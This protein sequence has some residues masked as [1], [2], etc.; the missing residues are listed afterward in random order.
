MSSKK[1]NAKLEKTESLLSE[2]GYVLRFEKGNFNSGYCVLEHRK[3]IVIN[4]FLDSSA[5]LQVISELIVRLNIDTN[6]LTPASKALY[7]KLMTNSEKADILH[8]VV[9]QKID[10]G[11]QNK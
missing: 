9:E 2:A 8:P 10:L 1:S 3:V 11:D 6:R 7:K 5:R 4:K